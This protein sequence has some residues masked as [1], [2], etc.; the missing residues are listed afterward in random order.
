MVEDRRRI[1][2][3]LAAVQHQRGNAPERIGLSHVVEIAEH[4]AGVV[5]ISDA[6][7]AQRHRHAA[8]IGRI[9][10]ADEDHG[11]GIARPRAG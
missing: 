2:Q 4:R 3:H 10:L 9:V 5:L 6:E 1:D 8:D 7:Q 11:C